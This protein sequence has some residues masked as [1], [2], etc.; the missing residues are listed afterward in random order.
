MSN[1]RTVFSQLLDLVPR[2]RFQTY[3]DNYEGD[4]RNRKL[5]CWSQ[6]CALFY[7]QVRQRDSLRGIVEGLKHNQP[8][9]IILE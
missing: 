4:K 9:F 8:N 5:N 6:F 7:S 1:Y 3:V 2:Y